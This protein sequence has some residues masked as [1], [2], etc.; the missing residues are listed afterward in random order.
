MQ[1]HSTPLALYTEPAIPSVTDLLVLHLDMQ[2]Y[3]QGPL[4]LT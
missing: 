4:L 2:F 1:S 3:H